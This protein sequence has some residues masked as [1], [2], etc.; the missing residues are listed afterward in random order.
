MEERIKQLTKKGKSSK[1]I[2]IILLWD[3]N[4]HVPLCFI[5]DHM[6]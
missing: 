2:Q 3:T 5:K 6:K 1:E 4:N